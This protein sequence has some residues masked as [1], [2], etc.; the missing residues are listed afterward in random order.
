MMS[1][2]TGFGILPSFYRSSPLTSATSAANQAVAQSL[3]VAGAS[4]A[5]GATTTQTGATAAAPAGFSAAPKLSADVIGTLIESQAQQT[6]GSTSGSGAIG[7]ATNLSGASATSDPTTASANSPSGPLTL[8]EIAKQFDPHNITNQQEQQLD[9]E[10][11]SSGALSQ[12][13]GLH[14]EALNNL[15]D[16]FNNQHFEIRNGQAV[17]TTPSAT[18]QDGPPDDLI[19]RFQQQVAE[20]PSF[21]NSTQIA[22]DQNILNVLN[23][24]DSIQNGGTA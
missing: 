12:Q 11:V 9:G 6:A 20:D 23:E 8:Q 16:L 10:L 1:T 4:S 2:I 21:G 19:Q 5:G 17:A 18:A 24:L 3:D 13:D 7:Q 15:E 22:S 14:F